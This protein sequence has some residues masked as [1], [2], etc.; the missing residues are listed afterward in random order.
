MRGGSV[1]N[2][3]GAQTPSVPS[4]GESSFLKDISAGGLSD[5]NIQLK[6]RNAV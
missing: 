3:C 5:V 1:Q 2:V 6:V 4:P